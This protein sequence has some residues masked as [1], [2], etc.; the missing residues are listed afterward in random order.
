MAEN[1]WIGI[2]VVL[3]WMTFIRVDKLETYISI[4]TTFTCTCKRNIIIHW[5]NTVTSLTS[6]IADTLRSHCY[7]YMHTQVC[8]HAGDDIMYQSRI[9]WGLPRLFTR[10]DSHALLR[11]HS[12]FQITFRFT[13]A[14]LSSPSVH[15]SWSH[16]S[17]SHPIPRLFTRITLKSLSW[18]GKSKSTRQSRQ[19][20]ASKWKRSMISM[21]KIRSNFSTLN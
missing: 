2:F 18:M 19:I 16:P 11:H 13:F 8:G 12:T 7:D 21:M 3:F 14:R 9:T 4:Q 20:W 1:A 6:L 15:A 17:W 10:T 5:W